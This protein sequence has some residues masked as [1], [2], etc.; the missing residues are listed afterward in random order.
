MK[1]YIT[2]LI[3]PLLLSCSDDDSNKGDVRIDRMGAGFI[4]QTKNENGKYPNVFHATVINTTNKYVTGHV[5]F[6]IKE[7]GYIYS[8]VQEVEN[9]SGYEKTFNASLETDK[10]IDK[11]Y[12]I[13]AE[14]AEGSK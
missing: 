2:F 1:K 3:L 4:G 7:Y 8:D 14:F 5:R 13:R 12:L 6:E 9:L 10:I 11:S